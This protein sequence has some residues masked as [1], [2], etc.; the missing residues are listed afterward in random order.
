MVSPNVPV[1]QALMDK[2]K[3]VIERSSRRVAERFHDV[4][5]D[6]QKLQ[7]LK[8]RK[9]K[10][11][12]IL[13]QSLRR[14][15]SARQSDSVTRPP[16]RRVY[17]APRTSTFAQPTRITQA[18]LLKMGHLAHSTD[19]RVTWL[20]RSVPSMI[21]DAILAALTPPLQISIDTLTMRVQAFENDM[22]VPE[23]SEIPPATTRDVHRED[24]T[25]D[26]LEVETDKELIE[27]KEESIY[28]D[29]SDL[30]KT[31]VQSVIHKSLIETSMGG[32]SRSGPFEET[33]GTDAKVSSTT[34]GTDA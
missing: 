21:E 6:H 19:V 18:M 33:S 22:V 23:T 11:E 10:A 34:P 24:T 12:R 4:V 1:C 7:N 31:I 14:A 32:S 26:A 16:D 17:M 20:E 30:E 2:I 25:V 15:R 13:I 5:L 3:L 27:I 29:L 9:N 8:M 28:G